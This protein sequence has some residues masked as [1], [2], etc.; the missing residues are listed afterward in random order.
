MADGVHV[1]DHTLQDMERVLA[2]G[3]WLAGDGY[4]LAD[5]VVVPYFQTLM[6]FGWTAFYEHL[7][8]V[9]AWLQRCLARPA[10]DKAIR[11]GLEPAGG[12]WRR[13]MAPI[14]GP[15]DGLTKRRE[16]GVAHS[17]VPLT[18][19]GLRAPIRL[20]MSAVGFIGRSQNGKPRRSCLPNGACDD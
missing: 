3:D 8:R 4:S 7:P 6:Q 19:A 20:G 2:D 10:Y 18:G 11:S 15:V 17:G 9:T 5:I 16:A 1:Y 14:A 12:P 13:G